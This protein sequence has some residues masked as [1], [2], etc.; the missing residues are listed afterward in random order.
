MEAKGSGLTPILS[1]E[2]DQLIRDFSNFADR[3]AE[4]R[5]DLPERSRMAVAYI[6]QYT[7]KDILVSLFI[8]NLIFFIL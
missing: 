5:T 8:E 4:L 6:S 3:E 2:Y 7:Y 1:E